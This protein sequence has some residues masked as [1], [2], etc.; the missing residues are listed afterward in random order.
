MKN[1]FL[2]ID[3]KSGL[4]WSSILRKALSNWGELHIVS[5]ANAIQGISEKNYVAIIIDAGA[6]LDANV[7]TA[8]LIQRQPQARVIVAT[9]SPTWRRAREAMRAGAIDYIRKSL[10]EK[11]LQSAIK[12][13]LLIPP[14]AL[15]QPKRR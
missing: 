8:R 10:D 3:N 13:A 2:L 5:E 15:S 1:L 12:A 4:Q 11:E 7:L 14:S 9:A 6:V